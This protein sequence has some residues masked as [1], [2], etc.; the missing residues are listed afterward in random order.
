MHT[1]L[2]GSDISSNFGSPD[3]SAPDLERM[4]NSTK[5][6][7][8]S[9]SYHHS[10]NAC[11]DSKVAFRRFPSQWPLLRP[12]LLAA[13][14]LPLPHGKQVQ[15]QPQVS[16]DLLLDPGL[17]LDIRRRLDKDTSSDDES[18]RSA[19]LLLFPCEQCLLGMY[20]WLE[21]ILDPTDQ[22]ERVH[23]KRGTKLDRIV[24][25]TRGKCQDCL[26]RFKDDGLA[27]S[28]NSPFFVSP[29]VQ[30]LFV[31]LDHQNGERSVDVLHRF[32]KLWLQSYKKFSLSMT[33]KPLTLFQPLISE[34]KFSTCM[35]VETELE[36]QFSGL[37]QLETTTC[38]VFLLMYLCLICPSPSC[39]NL[40]VKQVL[41]PTIARPMCDGRPFAAW[42]VEALPFYF[43]V[44]L[45]CC[46]L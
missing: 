24:F 25:D 13:S 36:N 4:I 5:S 2:L 7:N 43:A 8:K 39:N 19:V 26:A 38:I 42:R 20:A 46:R 17:H 10:H 32:G 40:L 6:S 9:C 12:K 27:Y 29:R 1:S 3:G 18:A 37:P 11:P 28:V 44:S 45:L 33:P 15:F 14:Q 21:K 16:L 23:C 31:N 34:H 30:F 41:R 22:S 35:T